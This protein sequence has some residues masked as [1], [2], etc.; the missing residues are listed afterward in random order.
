M[1]IL[2]IFEVQLM[3]LNERNSWRLDGKKKLEE[4]G[5][6]AHGLGNLK[7]S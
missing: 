6:L 1:P 4:V 3:T 2:K 5:R 7:I